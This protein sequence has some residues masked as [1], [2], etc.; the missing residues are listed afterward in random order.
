MRLSELPRN[1]T[2]ISFNSNVSGIDDGRSCNEGH[3]C[4][5]IS[6][7]GGSIAGAA[8]LRNPTPKQLL[9][10]SRTI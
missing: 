3:G 6:P 5:S 4:F 2:G 7:N 10:L 9:I 1:L 8:L